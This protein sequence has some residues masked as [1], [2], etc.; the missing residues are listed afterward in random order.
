[1]S[2][3]CALCGF[4][5]DDQLVFGT[6]MSQV[7]Q[8]QRVAARERA[9]PATVIAVLTAAAWGVQASLLVFIGVFCADYPLPAQNDCLRGA[10]Q[11]LVLTGMLA[12]A[13]VIASRRNNLVLTIALAAATALGIVLHW[14]RLP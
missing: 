14:T 13:T 4:S 11:P 7:H 12:A 8:W 5:S 6:H 1:M 10:F 2:K 3:S 9:S